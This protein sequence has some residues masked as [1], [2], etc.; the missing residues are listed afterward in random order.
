[1]LAG[2]RALVVGGAS[3]IGAAIAARFE[4]EG[5]SV[6]VADVAG[7]PDIEIDVRD[8]TAVTVGVDA[9]LS[10]L[11]GLD[12]LVYAAGRPVVGT[13]AEVSLADWEDGLAINTRGPLLLA[14]AAWEALRESRGSVVAIASAAGLRPSA[15]Q[16]AY[17][18]SKAA[19]V[20]LVRCLAVEGAADGIR[21][22]S[23]CPG[24]IETPML[25]SFLAAQ[26]APEAVREQLVGAHPLGR[27]GIPDDIAGAAAYLAG[28]D[29]AWI[30]GT[31][32][33]VDGGLGVGLL[34]PA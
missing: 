20:M 31:E 28:D 3:G 16:A 32:Q 7:A 23:I 14:R 10:R 29:A 21:A 33:I 9:A 8:E 2:K 11:G 15:G 13:A 18:V 27:L 34:G 1:M 4:R 5:A 22:N 30:T 6:L 26:A 19:C 12:S 24:F 17:C 25:A